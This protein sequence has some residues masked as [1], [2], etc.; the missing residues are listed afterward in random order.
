MPE[1]RCRIE[2]IAGSGC[3][4]VKRSKL[5]GLL[6]FTLITLR[7]LTEADYLMNFIFIQQP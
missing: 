4:I 1:I 2:A 6:L 5:T 3:L 7:K